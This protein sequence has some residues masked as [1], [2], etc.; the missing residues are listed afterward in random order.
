MIAL[1]QQQITKAAEQNCQAPIRKLALVE[2][3]KF[4]NCNK[5]KMQGR[6]KGQQPKLLIDYDACQVKVVVILCSCSPVA[7]LGK[8]RNICSN[9]KK[10]SNV[11]EPLALQSLRKE[12]VCN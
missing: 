9:H 5:T 10:S 7:S 4:L 1:N 11:S 12:S 6:R 2:N 8:P 3:R